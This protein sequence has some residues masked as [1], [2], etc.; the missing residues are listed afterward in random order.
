M[1]IMVQNKLV[2]GLKPSSLGDFFCE[3]CVLGRMVKKSFGTG[4]EKETEPGTV[5][6]SDICGPFSQESLGKSR[7]YVLFKCQATAFRMVYFMK[8]KSETLTML[9]QFLIDINSR[10]KWKVK[11]LRTD[12]GTEYINQDFKNFCIKKGIRHETSPAY[13]PQMNGM[14][15]RENGTLVEIARA[16]IHSKNLPLKLWAEAVSCAAHVLNRRDNTKTP[17]EKW[18]GRKPNVSHFRIFGTT[19]YVL[20]PSHQRDK[21]D[22]TGKRVIFVGYGPSDKLY[23]V[24]DNDRITVDVVRDIKFEE[25]LP[26]RKVLIHDAWTDEQEILDITNEEE[27]QSDSIEITDTLENTIHESDNNDETSPIELQT[28]NSETT[29]N[30]QNAGNTTESSSTNEDSNHTTYG[31]SNI[32]L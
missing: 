28:K 12:N 4:G 21:L 7:Y 14:S 32:H 17:Y 8:R 16:M 23:R 19:A 1:K 25:V 24:Y 15:E 22:A 5:I 13:T 30:Q 10:T 9:K 29:L 11:T 27:T 26:S 31:P 18:F 6:H 20:V 3:G 2:E